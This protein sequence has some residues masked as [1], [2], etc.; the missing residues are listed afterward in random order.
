MVTPQHRQAINNALYARRLRLPYHLRCLPLDKQDQW[1]QLPEECRYEVQ[2]CLEAAHAHRVVETADY[3]TFYPQLVSSAYEND[4]YHLNKPEL[5]SSPLLWLRFPCKTF[6]VSILINP[7]TMQY[8]L[9]TGPKIVAVGA[10]MPPRGLT[11]KHPQSKNWLAWFS[12][13]RPDLHPHLI[14]T[15]E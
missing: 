4:T 1:L 8:L 5:N 13:Q 3:V 6:R 10:D 2:V 9:S 14:A 7:G 12:A 15:R 11:R